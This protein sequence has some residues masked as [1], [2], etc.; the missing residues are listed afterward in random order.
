ME[1]YL[2]LIIVAV[3][4]VTFTAI[5]RRYKRCPSDKIL[6]IY[7]KTGKNK[8]G[9]ISSARCIHG[10]ASFIWPVFQ[11]YAFL[12]L[13]PIS[14][15]CNLTN[16]LSK[17]NI[18]VDVPCRF[19]VGIS[20]EPENMTNAAER[21]LGLTTEQIQNIATDILFG[22]LRLVIA[23]MDIEEINADRDK[24]LANVST[25]VEAE[26]RKI[27]LKLINVNVTDIR[28]ESGYI[29][30]LG[31]E[32]AAKAINDAKKSVAEQ[33]RYGEIGKAEADRDKDIR[34]AETTRDTRI[35]TADANAKAVE[36]ENN[37]KIAIAQSDA[38]RREKQAEAERLAV[39]AEK[40]QAAKALEEAY[41]SE[42]D[43]ELARAEREKATQQAN[44]VVAAQIEK[45]KAIIDAEAEAEQIRRKAKGEAD[46]I[47]AKMDAQ[48][49]GTLE[50]LSKQAAGFG[51][52]VAAAGGDAQQAITMLI[53]DKL[54][55]LVATQVEAVKGI[56]I[57]KVT[58]WD[59]GNGTEGKTATSNFISGLMKSVPPLEDLFKLAGMELPSYLKGKGS[60]RKD[61]A[62]EIKGEEV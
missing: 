57:D 13:T 14:I 16:A 40:V 3:V 12:D 53:T 2:I 18:R 17:Q 49:R 45:E 38:T 31:K 47:F 10:G 32:A 27:G 1:L 26:L 35:R 4:F 11:S 20:T 44:I 50:I 58:V 8:Q 36:G 60:D 59:T 9:G 24:F 29:E 7:G 5:L 55:E 37:S 30:A 43:A 56:N 22:Q 62:E 42:R 41:K 25:N 23:T 54:P 51:Q 34:I 48:A 15:E 61:G 21:L 52:L 39:A 33:N 46:A 28:D 6:V 19:T